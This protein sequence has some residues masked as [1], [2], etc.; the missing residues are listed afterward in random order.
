MKAETT[1]VV[2]QAETLIAQPGR[3]AVSP[4]QCREQ[5]TLCI[6]ETAAFAQNL[7]RRAGHG[8]EAIIAGM[9]NLISN[10]FKATTCYGNDVGHTATQDLSPSQDAW[11]LPIADVGGSQKSFHLLWIG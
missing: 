9:S 6:A 11:M 1:T 5:M 2:I 10:P 8:R 3:N 7:R 4:Q